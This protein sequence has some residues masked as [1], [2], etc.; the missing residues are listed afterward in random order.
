LHVFDIVEYVKS[1][2]GQ[3]DLSHH[4]RTFKSDSGLLQL[5]GWTV[6]QLPYIMEEFLF[7]SERCVGSV[8]AKM[9]QKCHFGSIFDRQ[10]FE[11]DSGSTASKGSVSESWGTLPEQKH[12]TSGFWFGRA[13]QKRRFP[14]RAAKYVNNDVESD[15]RHL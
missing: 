12:F 9:V 2:S 5:P 15:Q 14:S 10:T 1:R 8:L 6:Q 13:T 3:I 7:N 4:D 11:S